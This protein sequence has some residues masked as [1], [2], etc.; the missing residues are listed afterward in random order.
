MRLNWPRPS[1]GLL[2]DRD[3]R[4]YWTG[5]SIS[6]MGSAVS[7]V[8][9]PLT[10]VLVLH[11][12]AF[13]VGMLQATAWLPSLIVGLPA[14]AWVER[15]RKRPVLLAA[16]IVSFALF[17]S[18]PVAAWAGV[19]TVWQ[20]VVVAFLGG[21]AQVFFSA[22]K[23]PFVR[24]VVAQEN[25]AEAY[26]KMEAS[27]WA[28]QIVAPG[29]AGLLADL[30]GAVTGLLANA[31]S[32]LVSAFCLFRIRPAEPSAAPDREQGKTSLR[33]DIAEGLHF[34]IR[35]PYLRVVD[36]YMGV[37]NFG[38][39]IMEAAVVVFLVK[40]VGVS[41]GVAGL[42]MAATGCGGVIGSL[43]ATR[44]GRRLG[45]ARGLL[46]YTALASPLTLLLPLTS[47][48]FGMTWFAAG[49]LL[50][51]VG[52][53]VSNVLAQTFTVNYV[54]DH[55]L[56]RESSAANLLIRGTQPLG[57]VVGAVIGGSAGPRAAMW[58]AAAVITLSA[59]TLF[60]GPIRQR[61][62]LPTSYP[63]N[64]EAPA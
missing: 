55:L 61:R 33:R 24:S 12:G 20:L 29:L 53:S 47:R 51:V 54:P 4:L 39:C 37:A 38:D 11:A 56:S 62:D 42:L 64:A 15:M 45:S 30:L 27:S 34:L 13:E 58:A 18:V 8:A 3:Y 52:V 2:R 35:D 32:F 60:I 59:G 5:E 50:Y 25:R 57:A 36:L 26:A 6:T 44:I 9:M 14:G 49:M 22:A 43:L 40:T 46:L 1:L 23:S 21:V 10:A 16:D 17:A 48:G 63:G 28:G 31:I 41:A 7:V 19:L